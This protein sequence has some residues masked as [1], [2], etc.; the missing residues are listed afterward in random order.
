MAG[1]LTDREV[2]P[3]SLETLSVKRSRKVTR[4]DDKGQIR[5]LYA[6]EVITKRG[7]RWTYE[8]DVVSGS[9]SGLGQNLKID[10]H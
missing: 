7:V 4:L 6:I 10:C 8:I 1:K 3:S 5:K 2:A 9:V